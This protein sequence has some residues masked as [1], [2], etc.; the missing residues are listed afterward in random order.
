MNDDELRELLALAAVDALGD[1]ERVQL[2]AA[3]AD[4]PDLRAELESLRDAAAAMA[5]AVSE[6]PPPDLR[7]RLL[8]AI[9]TTPQLAPEAP[10]VPIGA[11]RRRRWVAW[12][13]AAAAVVALA[14]G[15]VVVVT[16]DG[17]G[18]DQV[19]EV[20]AAD[21]AVTI[22]MPGELAGLTIVHSPSEDAAVVL[23][24]DVPVPEGDRV[25]ELWAIRDGTPEP[26]GTF[27]PASDG[28][29]SVYLAGLDPASA[30]QWAVT[31]EPAG[32]SD[33]PTPPIL[34]ATA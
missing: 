26:F 7:G 11:A 9:A 10:V 15:A 33:T 18:E 23:A 30:E 5:D 2:E 6:E 21:D 34:N 4:R 8:S 20:I 32:G 12:G 29:L 24:D 19:A 25:Y 22:P 31:E 16:S 1:D 17:D 13:A 27:R 3:L 28:T 14:V